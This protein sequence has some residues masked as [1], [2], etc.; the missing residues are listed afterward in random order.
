[1]LND[2]ANRT[3]VPVGSDP[4]EDRIVSRTNVSQT[5]NLLGTTLQYIE[6]SFPFRLDHVPG[7]F[8]N[9]TTLGGFKN[10]LENAGE[11]GLPFLIMWNAEDDFTDTT[12][13]TDSFWGRLDP[14]SLGRALSTALATGR[15]NVGYITS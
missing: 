6:R 15:R 2:R 1:M 3:G 10:F 14:G 11:L 4:N 13:E 7:S 9:D 5:G 12:F 8:V